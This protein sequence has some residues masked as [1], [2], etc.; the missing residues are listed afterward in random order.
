MELL[1][2]LLIFVIFLQ[3][4]SIIHDLMMKYRLKS[5]K[6]G[7]VYNYTI[8]DNSRT[9]RVESIDVDADGS[10]WILYE[11]S[12]DGEMKMRSIKDFIFTWK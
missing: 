11:D 3:A 2:F 7:K 9:A 12:L 5:V 10:K 1:C 6:I 8:G 4:P